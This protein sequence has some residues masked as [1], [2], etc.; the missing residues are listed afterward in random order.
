MYVRCWLINKILISC[1]RKPFV[2]TINMVFS[3]D[4]GYD[5]TIIC[6]TAGQAFRGTTTTVHARALDTINYYYNILCYYSVVLLCCE[7]SRLMSGSKVDDTINDWS[8]Y[9]DIIPIMFYTRHTR[10]AKYFKSFNWVL[11]TLYGYCVLRSVISK[12]R[13]N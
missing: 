2:E 11:I 8:V 1:I 5:R 3:S 13:K 12:C 4:I 6:Y 10:N 7:S 9:I